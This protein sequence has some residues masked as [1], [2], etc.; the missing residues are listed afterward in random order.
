M[1]IENTRKLEKWI[2]VMKMNDL[3]K[4]EYKDFIQAYSEYI[5]SVN[6]DYHY[7]KTYLNTYADGFFE[8]QEILK[9][10]RELLLNHVVGIMMLNNCD[11]N[12]YS[13]VVDDIWEY[14]GGDIHLHNRFEKRVAISKK[15]T[16]RYEYKNNCNLVRYWEGKDEPDIGDKIEKFTEEFINLVMELTDEEE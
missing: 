13:F 11:I 12:K 6:P 7:N 4:K 16:I 15:V 1:E 9:R 2:S 3:K 10:K 14:R 8:C 5:V